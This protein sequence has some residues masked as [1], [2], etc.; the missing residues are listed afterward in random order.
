MPGIKR[1][2][3]DYFNALMDA[4]A[5]EVVEKNKPKTK[6]TV[7]AET[8]VPNNSVEVAIRSLT[9]S[10]KESHSDS[11]RYSYCED[12]FKIVKTNR[13]DISDFTKSYA[14]LCLKT[15]SSYMHSDSYRREVGNVIIKITTGKLD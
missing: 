6:K 4:I 15:I 2:P 10:A 12:I 11:Y 1:T 3:I 13:N 7:T 5:E 14:I 9:L 8:H